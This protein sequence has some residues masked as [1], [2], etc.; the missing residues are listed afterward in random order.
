M[1][2][3]LMKALNRL[4]RWRVVFA[5]WQLGTRP[6]DDPEAQAV[7]DHRELTILLRAE[8]SALS[9]LL[10]E[11]GVITKAELYDALEIEAESLS[12]HYEQK[13]PGFRTTDEGLSL[14]PHIA[15]DTMQGWR[16]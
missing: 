12:K 7:R 8:S 13:F 1:K 14:S 4:A 15:K 5:G 9:T 10:V 6:S 2:P 11:K 3:S 16:P